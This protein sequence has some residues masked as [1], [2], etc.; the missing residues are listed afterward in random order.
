MAWLLAFQLVDTFEM[1]MAQIVLGQG[2]WH[3]WASPEDIQPPQ[4]PYSR[5][6]D[7]VAWWHWVLSGAIFVLTATALIIMDQRN[8]HKRRRQ[9]RQAAAATAIAS[10]SHQPLLVTTG[11]HHAPRR[12]KGACCTCLLLWK[13][14]PRLLEFVGTALLWT[15]ALS[16]KRTLD[17]TA[18]L[19]GGIYRRGTYIQPIPDR[20]PLGFAYA[21]AMVVAA[22]CIALVVDLHVHYLLKRA[23]AV[24]ESPDRHSRGAVVVLRLRYDFARRCGNMLDKCLAYT[25]ASQTST[26]VLV[27]LRAFPN[28]HY[29]IYAAASTFIGVVCSVLLANKCKLCHGCPGIRAYGRCFRLLCCE[30]CGCGTRSVDPITDVSVPIASTGIEDEVVTTDGTDKSRTPLDGMKTMDANRVEELT[31]LRGRNATLLSM[32]NAKSTEC[33]ELREQMAALRASRMLS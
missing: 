14:S 8:R 9:C 6:S 16:L 10:S 20:I 26:A 15:G 5:G 27:A 21:G 32:L 31:F 11:S 1:T 24:A 22:L 2:S 17:T 30:D 29:W 12:C 4:T 25:S 28:E 18:G 33:H 19:H 7:L 3:L 13:Q 23:V